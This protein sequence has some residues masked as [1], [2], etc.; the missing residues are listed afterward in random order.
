MMKYGNLDI[1]APQISGIPFNETEVLGATVWL[2]MHSESHRDAPLHTLS[3]LLLPAIT[4][5]Q[6][7]L[8]S[9]GIKP[10]FYLSWA[11][12]NKDAE[13]RYLSNHSACMPIE[14]WNSGERMWILDWVAPFGHTHRLRP[15]IADLFPNRCFRGL[16]HR[17]NERGARIM[18]YKGSGVSREQGRSWFAAHPVKFKGVQQ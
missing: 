9:E 8:I 15:L 3:S 14:D 5:R 17:G 18:K 4:L 10:V 13:Q 11:I 6:F 2:W 7:I 12:M 16:Q 1:T